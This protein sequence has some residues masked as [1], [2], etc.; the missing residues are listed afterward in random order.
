MHPPCCL[1]AHQRNHW[2]MPRQ[3]SP[4]A[5]RHTS[6]HSNRRQS[7]RDFL[8]NGGVVHGYSVGKVHQ[9]H[10]PRRR[11]S[12]KADSVLFSCALSIGAI[13]HRDDCLLVLVS[14]GCPW[15]HPFAALSGGVA[16]TTRCHLKGDFL[17]VN[18]DVEEL[19]GGVYCLGGMKCYLSKWLD[20]LPNIAFRVPCRYHHH[21]HPI[22]PTQCCS[23]K[24]I[25]V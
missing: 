6:W 17:N 2:G 13:D 8:Q 24:A 25:L 10:L 3:V 11:L 4:H 7:I 15:Q 20:S 21:F 22:S 16:S 9:I 18:A 19:L 12:N 5:L 23:T 1:R 14:S